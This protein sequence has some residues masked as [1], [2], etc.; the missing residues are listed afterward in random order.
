MADPLADLCAY[1]V[2]VWLDDPWRERPATGQDAQSYP[3]PI[4]GGMTA[5]RGPRGPRLC[6]KG[7]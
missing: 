1:G 2:S 4:S 6:E 5:K 7:C 3:G